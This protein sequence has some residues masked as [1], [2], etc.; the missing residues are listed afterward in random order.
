MENK[1]EKK[2]RGHI[3]A[4]I[5]RRGIKNVRNYLVWLRDQKTQK[6]DANKARARTAQYEVDVIG[7]MIE[8]EKEDK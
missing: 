2:V 8:E 3:N 4:T 5:M 1:A 6:V 7:K